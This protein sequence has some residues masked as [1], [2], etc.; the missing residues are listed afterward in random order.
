MIQICENG[1]TVLPSRKK[2]GIILKGNQVCAL[3]VAEYKCKK[4]DKITG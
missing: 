2:G 4:N 3:T 1:S